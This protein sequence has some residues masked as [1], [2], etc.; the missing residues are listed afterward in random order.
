VH[1]APRLESPNVST[2]SYWNGIREY[3]EEYIPIESVPKKDAFIEGYIGC[4]Q[5]L[6]HRDL[7]LNFPKSM[8]QDM[9]DW[10]IEEDVVLPEG[11]ECN[12]HR[13]AGNFLEWTWHIFFEIYP[14]IQQS[15]PDNKRVG[16]FTH[17]AWLVKLFKRRRR[18]FSFKKTKIHKCFR[19]VRLL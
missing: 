11:C 4:A 17:I 1:N 5:F 3:V 6:V 13:I 16:K 18:R 10:I 7:I 8:Y 19:L 9:Y 12:Q 14:R 15:L 2:K